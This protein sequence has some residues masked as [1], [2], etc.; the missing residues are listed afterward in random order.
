[1]STMDMSIYIPT[2]VLEG[3]LFSTSSPAFIVCRFIDDV[4]SDRC[5]VIPHCSFDL[6]FSN[7][8]RSWASFMCWLAIRMPSLENYLFRSSAHENFFLL[9]LSCKSCLRILE[10]NLLSHCFICYYFLPFGGLSFY[11]V[12]SFLCYTKVF[13]FN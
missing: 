9:M 13:K 6:H 2:T 11:L 10:I 7:N 4:H 3:S 1:M 5:E 8:K 12:Y